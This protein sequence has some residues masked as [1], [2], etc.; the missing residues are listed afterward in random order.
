MDGVRRAP[1]AW[2]VAAVMA[3]LLCEPVHWV[4]AQ[5]SSNLPVGPQIEIPVAE[6]AALK[7]DGR[8]PLVVEPPT[9]EVG[10]CSNAAEDILSSATPPAAVSNK[11]PEVKVEMQTSQ[12]GTWLQILRLIRWLGPWAP[13]T[14]FTLLLLCLAAAQWVLRVGHW[15]L[16]G[17]LLEMERWWLAFSPPFMVDIHPLRYCTACALLVS[18]V[19]CCFPVVIHYYAQPVELLASE[20]PANWSFFSNRCF[21]Y[22][23]TGFSSLRQAQQA[24]ERVGGQLARARTPRDNTFLK[25]LVLSVG[26][27]STRFDFQDD[28]LGPK[29]TYGT[30]VWHSFDPAMENVAKCTNPSFPDGCP[31][32][33]EKSPEPLNATVAVSQ[34]V[35]T[36]FCSGYY[37]TVLVLVFHAPVEQLLCNRFVLWVQ[38]G[39]D[40]EALKQLRPDWLAHPSFGVVLLAM[41]RNRH[42]TRRP[43]L[44]LIQ[45]LLCLAAVL[46][47]TALAG[48]LLRRSVAL[49]LP[50]FLLDRWQHRVSPRSQLV[51]RVIIGLFSDACLLPFF[52]VLFL[53]QEAL[54]DQTEIIGHPPQR[55]SVAP[56]EPE[57]EG[58][59]QAQD[60][61]EEPPA[62]ASCRICHDGGPAL[63]E[64]CAC[65]GS[66]AYAH[67]SCLNKWR[68]YTNS[69]AVCDVCRCPYTFR[70]AH[71]RPM[72][73]FQLLVT[74]TGE[75][76]CRM[77]AFVAFVVSLAGLYTQGAILYILATKRVRIHYLCTNSSPNDFH[78][79]L[80]HQFPA[81]QGPLPESEPSSPDHLIFFFGVVFYLPLILLWGV[82]GWIRLRRRGMLDDP[83]ESLPKV[84]RGTFLLV[85]AHCTFNHIALAWPSVAGLVGRPIPAVPEPLGL[86]EF[87]IANYLAA[88]GLT[89]LE[90][91]L[92]QAWFAFQ[93]ARQRRLSQQMLQ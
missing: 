90:A 77:I 42:F 55:Q 27:M 16:A 82:H 79:E 51:Q 19:A 87:L 12:D 80:T 31:A 37:A 44:Y 70:P 28:F 78:F 26:Q 20:C 43:R 11:D 32:L 48:R 66:M 33:C 69:S 50:E 52:Y 45:R 13:L 68:E 61:E 17:L 23:P 22:V 91:G 64:P 29:E 67:S 58:P 60:H 56:K 53:R 40:L 84:L 54:R 10:T 92:S 88:L 59:G 89:I 25:D 85:T 86:R 81:R 2:L 3:C 8:S 47:A 71:I 57:A 63:I 62:E 14:A 34:L 74:A 39:M 46:G 76:V 72:Q 15:A 35:E 18:F 1:S 21:S 36:L 24:C 38:N 73:V 7:D 30:Q 75:V 5:S 93:A 41:L 6:V 83:A 49:Y 65:R 4:R 9:V